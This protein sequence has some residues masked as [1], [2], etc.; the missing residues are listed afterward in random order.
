MDPSLSVGKNCLGENVIEISSEKAEGHGDW[1]S[2]EYQDTA[3]SRGKKETKAMVFHKMDTEEISDRYMASCFVNGLEAYDGEINLGMEENMISNTFAMNLCLEHKVKHGNKVVKKEL[4]VAL[5]GY[6]Y[7]IKF[8]INLEED[9]VEP[10]VVFGRSFMHLTKGIANFRNRTVIIYP[11]LDPF[12]V[13]SKEEEKVGDDWD[14]L[15]DVLD[16]GNIPDIEGVKVQPFVYMGPSL[17]TGKPLTR[18]EAEKEALDIDIYKRYSL[19]EEEILV[20]ETMAYSDK[21]K[22]ILDGIFLDKMKL[23][24]EMKKEEEQAITKVEGEA[25]IEKEDPGAFVIPIRL[26]GKINLN[27]VAD[28]GSDING[29]PYHVYKELA[30]KSLDTAESD[31]DEEEEYTMRAHND[32]AGSSRSKRSRQYETVEEVLLPQF[33]IKIAR[34]T[35]FLSDEVPR[36]LSAPIY[37]KDLDTT[38]L[39]ELIDTKGRLILEAP[40]PDVPRVG[41]PRPPRAYIHDLYD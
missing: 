20:I 25:L 32:E 13:S 26:E 36:S 29:I 14:L 33:I 16:F 18:N 35:R 4:I 27:A 7:F 39:R 3:N 8:I 31:S 9:D 10:G 6:I 28:N 38:T 40:E 19:V 2:L 17:S 22:K 11:K 12:L 30:K 23:D 24:G 1:N 15:L 37:C 41:I 5:R 21:Y 34:K